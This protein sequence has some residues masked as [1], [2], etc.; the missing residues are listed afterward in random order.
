MLRKAAQ[1]YGSQIAAYSA[2]KDQYKSNVLG[3]KLGNELVV[4]VLSYPIFHEVMT[5]DAFDARPDNFF[6]RLRT[7]GSR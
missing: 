5:N 4:V 6:L 1:K 2:W 7:M 3:L